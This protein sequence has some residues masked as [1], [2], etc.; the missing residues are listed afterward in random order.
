MSNQME[1]D[2]D[3]NT[4]NKSLSQMQTCRNEL[5]QLKRDKA[6]AETTHANQMGALQQ[7]VANLAPAREAAA[8]MLP[9]RKAIYSDAGAADRAQVE[10]DSTK[11]KA[12]EWFEDYRVRRFE[13]P[14]ANTVTRVISLWDRGYCILK[15]EVLPQ[16]SL[17]DDDF[18]S[19]RQVKGVRVRDVFEE[20][21]EDNDSDDSEKD[22]PSA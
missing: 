20:T 10:F 19:V 15:V 9:F 16:A 4:F 13:D 21:E 6:A 5:Q 22:P 7:Q 3:P 11:Q 1:I 14:L 18:F 2:N 17:D 12:K 8:P